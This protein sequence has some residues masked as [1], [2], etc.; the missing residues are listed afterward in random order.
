[1]STT[2]LP[3]SRPGHAAQEGT[4]RWPTAIYT[5]MVG[6]FLV[7]GLGFT[8]P[9]LPYRLDHLHLTTRT[10]SCILAAFGAGWLLGSILC[11]RLADRIGHR[12]TLI[13]AMVLA[14]AA[15]PLLAQAQTVPGLA[16]AAFTAGIVYDAPRPVFTAA[17]AD[18]FP[19]DRVRA[20]VNAWRNFAVNVGA[21]VAGTVGGLLAGPIG[22]PALIWTNAAACALFALLVWQ[23]LPPTQ[24]DRPVT[25][26]H[27]PAG[28][29]AALRDPLLW[30]LLAASL[31]ALTCAASLFS[32]MPMLMAEHGLT[33]SDYGWTQTANAGAVLLL[34]PI[35]NRWLVARS[36]R[37]TPMTGLLAASSVVLGTTMG[38]AGFAST[39][40]G[41][42]AA[43]AFAVPGE[44]VAFGAAADILNRISPARARGLYAGIWGTTL[45]VA[46]LIAP[47]LAG[48]AL[49]RGGDELAAATTFSVGLL[50]A[51]LS[52]PLTRLVRR[53][54]NE[55]HRMTAARPAT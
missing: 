17:I 1:M 28:Y 14:S 43:A 30:L 50:G 11:G 6:T 18:T 47:A 4:R 55:L 7:R 49:T 48:W 41:Y 36:D 54:R 37:P 10:V 26:D 38:A 23:F 51:G 25:A 33:A 15:L 40:L 16:A 53:Q 34:S 22:I 45:A 35:L 46:V 39:T 5:L 19:E 24:P 2:A 8:Y 20:S 29:R 3:V 13:A 27:R 44:I 52:W 12:T 42:C 31:C 9:F 21:A 32:S